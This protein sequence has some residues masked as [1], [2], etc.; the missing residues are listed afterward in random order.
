M[1][2]HS[3]N[4]LPRS[5]KIIFMGTPEFALPTLEALIMADHHIQCIVTQPDRPKGRGKRMAPPPVKRLGMEHKIDVL[6]PEWAAEPAFLDLLNK[7]APDLIIVVA[8][9]QILKKPLL[10]IPE[11]GVINIHPSLLP[12]YR[13]AAPIQRAI[14]NREKETG[15]SVMVLNEALDSGPVLFQERVP[16][17]EED[18]A[19]QL[20]DRLALNAGKLMIKSLIHMNEHTIRER[21]QD[22]SKASYAPKIE[23]KTGSIDWGQSARQISALMRALDPKPGAFTLLQGKEVKL[24]SPKVLDEKEVG[25]VPGRVSGL[26]QGLCAETGRGIIRVGEIQFAGRKRIPVGDFLRGFPVEEGTRLG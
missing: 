13:G 4:R 16:I 26:K 10:V 11:W 2:P 18:T 6:Q 7:K 3:K 12:K 1:P 9:G 19:G 17:G 5:P 8:Y 23:R 20:H 15:L 25:G 22:D 24:Y 21:S 14:L